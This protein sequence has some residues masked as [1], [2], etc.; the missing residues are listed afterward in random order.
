[1]M[2]IESAIFLVFME[3]D[4]VFHVDSLR[5]FLYLCFDSK[6]ENTKNGG[7][8]ERLVRADESRRVAWLKR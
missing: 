3:E 6:A 8:P 1:M 5:A 7:W 2:S 4:Q